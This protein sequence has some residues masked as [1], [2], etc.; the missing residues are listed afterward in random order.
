VLLSNYSFLHVLHFSIYYIVEVRLD[1]Y[2]FPLSKSTRNSCM[3]W[4]MSFYRNIRSST[5]EEKVHLHD[6][7]DLFH[8]NFIMTYTRILLVQIIK[9]V[10]LDSLR[11]LDSLP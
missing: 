1:L 8:F 4:R 2:I 7:V 3:Y 10:P 6:Q 11:I 5:A 9:I